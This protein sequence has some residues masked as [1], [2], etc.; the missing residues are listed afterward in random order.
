MNW[1]MVIFLDAFCALLRYF[2]WMQLMG[3]PYGAK[4]DEQM[5]PSPWIS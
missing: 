2:S 5:L 3:K 4:K 1:G